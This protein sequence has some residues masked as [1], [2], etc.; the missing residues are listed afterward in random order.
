MEMENKTLHAYMVMNRYIQY[1]LLDKHYKDCDQGEDTWIY[2]GSVKISVPTKKE[3]AIFKIK[4]LEDKRKII[5]IEYDN[6][7]CELE[8]EIRK[9]KTL[10]ESNG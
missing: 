9:L 10:E 3:Q 2:L 5:K 4:E 1:L 8:N 7:K 6:K